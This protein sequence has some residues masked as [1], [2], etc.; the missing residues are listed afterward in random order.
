MPAEP[1]PD[2]DDLSQPDEAPEP[3]EPQYTDLPTVA[4]DLPG[5]VRKL[6]QAF[7]A[8]R[9]LFAQLAEAPDILTPMV[10]L[11]L[12]GFLY[13][14]LFGQEAYRLILFDMEEIVRSTPPELLPLDQRAG[15]AQQQATFVIWTASAS[16]VNHI[17]QSGVYAIIFWW[18]SRQVGFAPKGYPELVSAMAFAWLPK[19]I[20]HLML[21][22]YLISTGEFNSWLDLQNRHAELALGLHS[23]LPKEMS[24]TTLA[25]LSAF[26]LL[27]PIDIFLVWAT[28]ILGIGGVYLLGK[29]PGLWK[30]MAVTAVFFVLF[31]ATVARLRMPPWKLQEAAKMTPGESILQSEPRA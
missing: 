1:L 14:A 9:A 16:G 6:G 15:A 13:M 18:L 7:V 29:G 28:I 21:D 27:G 11:T 31:S 10:F 3:S 17:L 8:P 23:F 12:L 24:F 30:L 2:P 25:E 20:Y 26:Y 4:L 19:P 22:G 5:R